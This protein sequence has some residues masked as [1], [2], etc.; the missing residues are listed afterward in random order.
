[1]IK[2]EAINI[3]ETVKKMFPKELIKDL[4]DD[5]RICPTCHGLGMRIEN[6]VY[7]IH[8]DTSEAGKRERFPYKHQA[9]S[10]CPDCYNGVQK[11]CEYC[12]QPFKQRGY[13][14]C[15]CEGFKK[16]EEE[17]RIAK[18]NDMVS[19]AKDVQEADVTTML[20]CEEFDKYF[21][22][23]DDFFEYWASDCDDEDII[24]ERLWVCSIAE[25]GID[26]ANVIENACSDLHEDASENCDYGS[27]QKLLDI[28]CK[29]QSGTT[30][31]YPCYDEY[32]TIDWI[33]T[34]DE[35]N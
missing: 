7:G 20:Y 28:W 12:K 21:I 29:E 13:Y 27:L 2:R 15:N 33:G 9:L 25:V 10:F 23:T 24:P 1:M 26:A 8:G 16:D 19:K 3:E 5:E 14:H 18:Y 34:N 17:K 30:T 32:I 4:Q 6:N 22:D 31:Y 11:L 35:Y